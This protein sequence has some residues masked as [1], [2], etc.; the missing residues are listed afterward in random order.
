MIIPY[1]IYDTQRN[2]GFINLGNSHDT[3][4]FACDSIKEWWMQ[5]GQFYYSFAK[6]ILLLCD[7]GGSNSSN[8]YIFKEDLQHLANEIGLEIRVA[9]Y[10]PHTSK[11]NPIEHRLFPHVTR[12]CQG[13]IFTSIELVKSL[14]EK[15]STKTGL[16]VNVNLTGKFYAKGRK[17][18]DGFKKNL[19]I[20]FDEYLPKWNYR[21]IPQNNQNA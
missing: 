4:E 6:S 1:G 8:Y 5:L 2:E 16:T 17:V 14:I 20:V 3:T 10:P 11:Y 7:G 12:A 9:H 21:A 15:T 13:A 19:P 18:V